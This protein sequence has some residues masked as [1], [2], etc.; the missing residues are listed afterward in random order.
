MIVF[1]SYVNGCGNARPV[2]E[3]MA[4]EFRKA[5]GAPLIGTFNVRLETPH[6][7]DVELLPWRIVRRGRYYFCLVENE[8][9]PT[10]APIPAWFI[11][12][13]RHDDEDRW[14]PATSRLEL[15]TKTPLPD[16]F[17][18]GRLKITIPERWDECR[19]HEWS[20]GQYWFQAFPWSE[21][22]RV[23]TAILAEQ[24]KT[25][26]WEGKR[27]LDFGC[28]TGFWAF[29]VAKAGAAHVVGI[30]R[31]PEIIE[32]AEFIRD[33]IEQENVYFETGENLPELDRFDVCIC[34]SVIHQFDE[35]YKT[36]AAWVDRLK[37]IADVVWLELI[38]P[39]LRG[40]MREAEVDAIVGGVRRLHY[41]HQIRRTRSL[42][43]IS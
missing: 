13:R 43:R 42:Y 9:Q 37:K 3:S 28:N 16:C 33:H 35:E 41:K 32:R 31:A 40:R 14:R 19:A 26:D 34:L 39:P 11:R 25:E 2:A 10:L 17:R 22:Q 20:K 21:K 38:N 36:L 4:D 24:F 7:H 18:S 1:G 5:F 29:E 23:D 6:K 27:V 15:Y 8:E 12:W 30:D